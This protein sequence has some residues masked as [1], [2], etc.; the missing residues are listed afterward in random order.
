MKGQH[1]QRSCSH[2]FRFNAMLLDESDESD[3]TDET[4]ETAA[5]RL[6]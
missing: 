6:A 2:H 1:R 3:E 5:T 4:V